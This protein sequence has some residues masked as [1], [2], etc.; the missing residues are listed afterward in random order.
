MSMHK[1]SWTHF[2]WCLSF[3]QSSTY[4]IRGLLLPN[5]QTFGN[6]WSLELTVQGFVKYSAYEKLPPIHRS[7]RAALKHRAIVGIYGAYHGLLRQSVLDAKC[8]SRK[9]I[10][11]QYKNKQ[12]SETFSFPNTPG[13]VQFSEIS[14]L[15]SVH[16]QSFFFFL[17]ILMKVISHQPNSSTDG[18]HN[19]DS[20]GMSI[21][22]GK[23]HEC[24][25]LIEYTVFL[26][27]KGSCLSLDIQHGEVSME[28]N[29]E[30]TVG[31]LA[32]PT[33]NQWMVVFTAAAPT[34]GSKCKECTLWNSV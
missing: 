10:H 21:E 24:F 30:G 22:T 11:Q 27:Q 25:Y 3:T 33:Q 20:S 17:L 18:L 15:K 29:N 31:Q 2:Y 1:K 23:N 34:Q 6:I 13:L 32:K 8:L 26:L 4:V 12:L 5:V 7:H 16:L 14:K 9:N 19:F 28:Q